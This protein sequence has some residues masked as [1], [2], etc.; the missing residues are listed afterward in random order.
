[1]NA[2]II[3]RAL[4]ALLLIISLTM[5][6]PVI[7]A[8]LSGEENLL[9]AFLIP[10]G[11]GCAVSAAGFYL[12]RSRTAQMLPRDG[13][14]IVTGSWVLA[15]AIGAVPFVLAHALPSY[16]DAFFETMSGFTTT[17]ASVIANVEALPRAILFWR[18]LTHWLGGM[19][20]IVLAV[21]VFPMIGIRAYQLV[22]AEAPGPSLERITPRIAHTAKILWLIYVGLSA[23]EAILLMIAGLSPFD[24]VTQTFGTMATGGFSTRNASI[25]AFNS[26]AVEIIITIFMVSA[27][28]NFVLYYHALVGRFTAI[29][30]DTEFKSYIGIFVV[31]SA[32]GAL[33]LG[34]QAGQPAG[35][36]IRSSAFQV[37]SILTTTGFATTNFDAWPSIAKIV[38]LLLMFVGGCAGSTAGGI[39]VVRIVTMLKQAVNEMRYEVHPRAVFSLSLN[40]VPL[41][42][43]TV[44]GIVSF[45]FLYMLLAL[46]TTAVVSFAGVSVQGAFTTALVTLGN[47]GPG[48]AEVG[49]TNTYM[50]YPPAI[51]W[52]LSFIMMVGRL[53]VYTVLIL[54]L[55]RM[56]RR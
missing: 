42:K 48:F 20:I 54:L 52:F 10:L 12:T 2:R 19:G 33:S 21:A 55:P 15:S 6:L 35:E 53:E 14:A 18:S 46:V 47:I 39:K 4:S 11:G 37:A 43:N 40:G 22:K 51:K 44:F 25:G 30:V 38:L 26:P 31:A 45:F 27:G 8:L 56:Y 13:F 24:A 29:K 49:P 3:F 23:L 1:M 41:R 17:G 28:A 9:S 7:V 32:I 34:L 5:L 36:A 50:F 16:T